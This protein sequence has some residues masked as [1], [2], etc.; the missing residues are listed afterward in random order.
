MKKH[1]IKFSIWGGISIAHSY[2][3]I[4][5]F[6][7]NRE[8]FS[9]FTFHFFTFDLRSTSVATLQRHQASLCLC[10]RCSI[11]SLLTFGRP[12]SPLCKAHA[13]MAL[14]SL[15]HRFTFHF[16]FAVQLA[17]QHAKLFLEALGEIGGG[18]EA[19]GIGYLGDCLVGGPQ[20][21]VGTQ[22]TLLA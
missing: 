8:F 16:L 4:G 22:E 7:A 3:Y 17:W 20:K 15:L 9:L 6:F 2:L 5:D 1:K 13:S 14:L 18:G 10:S 21:G 12:L 19:Y 11:G